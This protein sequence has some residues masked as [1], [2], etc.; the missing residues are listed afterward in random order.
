LPSQQEYYSYVL[1]VPFTSAL[2]VFS[3]RG[4][5]F[6]NVRWGLTAGSGIL[7]AGIT[8]A[9]LIHN[10]FTGSGH[11]FL[12]IYSLIIMWVGGFTLCYGPH[13]LRVSA[14]PLCFLLLMSPLPT[15]LMETLIVALQTASADIVYM[16]FAL[17]GVP[18]SRDGFVFSLPTL[19]IMVAKECSGINSCLGFLLTSLVVGHLFLRSSWKKVILSALVPP[20]LIM[21]NAVRIVSISL[22]A[23]RVD[24]SVLVGSIHRYGGILFSFLAIAALVPLFVG[25]YKTDRRLTRSPQLRPEIRTSR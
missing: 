9:L 2:L 19:N 3:E 4:K 21:K 14:F 15:S 11:L 18:V 22:L 24:R 20:V 10:A 23:I 17:L 12:A 1:F 16:F 13:A 25:L 6:A 5:I 7:L 8:L